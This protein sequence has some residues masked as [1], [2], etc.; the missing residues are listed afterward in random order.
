MRA[1][2][3]A[4]LVSLLHPIQG[5]GAE[6]QHAL[7]VTLPLKARLD[8][9]LHARIRTEPGGR[10][11]YQARS[12]PVVSWA[13]WQR[14]SLLGGYYYSLQESRVSGD[15][16]GAHRPFGGLEVTAVDARRL[17]VEQRYLAERF[18][19]EAAAGY[20]RHRLRTRVSAK[21]TVAPYTSHE[22]FYDAHGW[23][24][25][26]HAAGVRWSAHQALK[27]DV[28]YMFEHR[29]SALGP[30]RHIW[31]T[32]IQWKMPLRETGRRK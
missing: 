21:G 13:A 29:R 9:T 7:D 14:V 12:G 23:R 30:A 17:A 5:S 15:F 2:R 6:T 31:F 24:S 26:R 10:G 11:F 4:F 28:G 22:F 8:L 18:L 16:R 27:I 19:P 20:T 32:S 3:F 25:N 1:V